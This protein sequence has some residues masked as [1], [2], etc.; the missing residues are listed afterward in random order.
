MGDIGIGV[1][2]PISIQYYNMQ[3]KFNILT[4]KKEK[5]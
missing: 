1:A 3:L 4:K 5:E 2:P